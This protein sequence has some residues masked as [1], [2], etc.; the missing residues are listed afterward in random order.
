MKIE[1][2]YRLNCPLLKKFGIIQGL[3]NLPSLCVSCKYLELDDFSWRCK[4]KYGIFNKFKY[5]ASDECSDYE[6][7]N[8]IPCKYRCKCP[9]KILCLLQVGH[10]VINIYTSLLNMSRKQEKNKFGRI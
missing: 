6:L 2:I 5:F 7:D 10:Q 4:K 8:D 1:E 9:Q 3:T